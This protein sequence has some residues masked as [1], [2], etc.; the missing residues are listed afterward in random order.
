MF[1]VNYNIISDKDELL[2][3]I[4][5]LPETSERHKFYVSLLAR[6]KYNSS[7]TIDKALL[8]RKTC[9]KKDLFNKIWQ[10]EVPFGAYT[11]K[12]GEPVPQDAL[13]CYMTINPRDLWK[14]AI[15]STKSLVDIVGNG[16][17]IFNQNPHQVVMSNIHKSSSNRKYTIFDVDSKDDHIL[18][19]IFSIVGR[20]SFIETRGGYHVLVEHDKVK[21]ANKNWYQDISEFVEVDV[22]GDEM[23]PIP[24]TLQG[25]FSVKFYGIK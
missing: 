12:N 18:D 8:S 4:E 17:N 6:K 21:S 5:W 25:G 14:A 16:E 9:H 7:C 13:V 24:G 11:Q 20:H 15:A 23:S 1:R 19:N 3:F 22:V 10:M 2:R